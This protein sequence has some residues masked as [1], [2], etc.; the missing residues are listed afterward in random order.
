MDDRRLVDSG[1][2]RARRMIEKD[3][4][5]EKGAAR[6]QRGAFLSVEISAARPPW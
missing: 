4:W 3:A 6:Y 1:I 2:G 5:K